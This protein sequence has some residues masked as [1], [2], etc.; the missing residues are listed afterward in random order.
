MTTGDETIASNIFLAASSLHHQS[1]HPSATINKLLTAAEN[2]TCSL[3]K[4]VLF[5]L[6]PTYF[7][8]RN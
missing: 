3:I 8:A 6:I 5:T 4:H 2:K 7:V 1:V